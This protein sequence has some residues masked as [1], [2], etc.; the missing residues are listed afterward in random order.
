MMMWQGYCCADFL[1]ECAIAD[2]APNGF[3]L[4]WVTSCGSDDKDEFGCA[5]FD[6]PLCPLIPAF[7]EAKYESCFWDHCFMVN[8][9]DY[10]L[11]VVR[12]QPFQCVCLCCGLIQIIRCCLW[13]LRGWLCHDPM[14]LGLPGSRGRVRLWSS[15]LPGSLHTHLQVAESNE[16]PVRSLRQHLWC[17]LSSLSR[18][19]H[20]P[21]LL[22]LVLFRMSQTS[23]ID[24]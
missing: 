18:A 15:A 22:R 24:R 3:K 8:A 21:A 11:G 10:C 5:K 17:L 23:Q 7:D 1:E 19:L 20:A 4:T 14:H 9:T 6:F 12:G 16:G 2:D 13:L